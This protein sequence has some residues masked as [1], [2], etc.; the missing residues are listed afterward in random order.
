MLAQSESEN[1]RGWG[2]PFISSFL[3]PNET[4]I[5]SPNAFMCGSVS[6]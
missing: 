4:E 6:R 3:L 2:K 1:G 5:G